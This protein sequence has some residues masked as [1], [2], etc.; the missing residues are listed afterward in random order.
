LIF[1]T[2][3]NW[4]KGFD[5]LV[6]AVDELK[7]RKDITDDIIAQIGS[8]SYRPSNLKVIEYCSPNEFTKLVATSTIVISHAGMGTIGQAIKLGKCIIIIPRKASLGEHIDDHQYTTAK[9]LEV[10]GK[11]LVAYDVS[12]LLSRLKEAEKFVPVQ[13]KNSGKGIIEAIEEFLSELAT[14]KASR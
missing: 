4:H 2:V 10:E 1:L 8:G 13:S 14:R 5:R 6:K 12:D 9:Q 11:V 7:A 3:G